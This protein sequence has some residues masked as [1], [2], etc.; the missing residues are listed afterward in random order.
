MIAYCDRKVFD[1]IWDTRKQEFSTLRGVCTA[2]QLLL[3]QK[4]GLELTVCTGTCK[5]LQIQ[6]LRRKK[7]HKVQFGQ[8]T[9][10]IIR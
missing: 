3:K 9:F 10:D 8:N 4:K 1:V 5:I 2:A 6:I 7:S